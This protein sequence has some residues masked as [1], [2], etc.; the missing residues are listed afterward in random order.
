VVA[1]GFGGMGATL[2]ARYLLYTGPWWILNM[3]P[4]APT[5]VVARVP[6][7]TEPSTQY[8]YTTVN[9]NSGRFPYG[10]PVPADDPL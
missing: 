2:A 8:F 5:A 7:D 6:L 4:R 3:D 9:K 10:W 1:Q